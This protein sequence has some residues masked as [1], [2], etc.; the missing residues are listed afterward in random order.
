[1]RIA[2]ILLAEQRDGWT[3]SG[4][5]KDAPSA[6]ISSVDADEVAQ[7]VV[8]FASGAALD[9]EHLVIAV[10]SDSV[11]FA[12]INKSDADRIKTNGSLRY[13]LESVLPVDAESIV[14]DAFPRPLRADHPELLAVA[15][16]VIRIGSLVE[17]VERLRCNVQFIVPYSMLMVEHAVADKSL[18]CPSISIW[19]PSDPQPNSQAEI[20][21]IDA[22]H[23]VRNWQL[24]EM[25]ADAISRSLSFIGEEYS[26]FPVLVLGTNNK[27]VQQLQFI[28]EGVAAQRIEGEQLARMRTATLLSGR[29]EPWIDLR[30]DQ[31]AASDRLRRHRG[32]LARLVFAMMVLLLTICGTL[33][34]QASKYQSLIEQVEQKQQDLFRSAFPGQRVPSAILGRLRSEH[35]KAM[36]VRRLADSKSPSPSV[37][38]I[39]PAI[40]DSLAVDFPFEVKEIR[41]EAGKVS[42]ELELLSQEDA[43]H[44]AAALAKNGF[45]VE[46]PATTLINGDHILAS[47]VASMEQRV[48]S[49]LVGKEPTQ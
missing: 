29:D 21:V 31:L 42:I 17:A 13:A 48:Q 25:N 12:S 44:V 22:S 45:V 34:W 1:M 6:F 36:G 28:R 47:Y 46:P 32:P 35:A 49:S 3:V 10:Q 19:L 23:T 30:R 38:K 37:L 43:G 2:G 26:A 20:I 24:T 33:L 41:M 4:A 39:F 7:A 9:L 40:M 16:D 5:G 11:L 15:M 27:L 18:P 8:E 14:V